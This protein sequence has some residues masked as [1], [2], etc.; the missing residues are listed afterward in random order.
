MTAKPHS[1]ARLSC[2]D[3]LG[4]D[5]E[6]VQRT[7]VYTSEVGTFD[8]LL[9]RGTGPSMNK[10]NVEF[11]ETVTKLK[12]SYIATPSRKV[13]KQIIR[14]IV[15]DIKAKNGRFLTKLTKN[16]MKELGLSPNKDMYEVVSDGVALEKTKQAIRYV[17]YKKDPS[18][19][20][21]SASMDSPRSP[22]KVLK[23]DNN[24]SPSDLKTKVFD[25]SR[26]SKST[27]K[28]VSSPGLGASTP[29]F[30]LRTGVSLLPA[31]HQQQLE[32]AAFNQS[33]GNLL[34]SG[35]PMGS[36]PYSAGLHDF[37]LHRLSRGFSMPS[38]VSS[39]GHI[40]PVLAA[41]ASLRFSRDPFEQAKL[42][43]SRAMATVA[44]K[45]GQYG[46]QAN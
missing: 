34:A 46:G 38:Y 41:E 15:R 26:L 17:H 32:H 33:I 43:L 6:S 35:F 42:R 40:D 22:S 19:R 28:T 27:P 4:S 10:G 1:D 18:T 12:A 11:R 14:K 16:E 3:V 25:D 44:T 8:V 36:L 2:D 7:G 45:G 5:D 9:G 37:G 23:G 39:F 30:S 21:R 13:K 31:P 24:A 20:K 29:S